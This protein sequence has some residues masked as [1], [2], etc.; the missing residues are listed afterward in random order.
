VT[1]PT[2]ESDAPL[3]RESREVARGESE[4]TPLLLIGGV[5]GTIA[6]VAGVLIVVM[7]LIWRFL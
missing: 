4:K 2:R 5:G 3:E 6:V 1:E 7:L